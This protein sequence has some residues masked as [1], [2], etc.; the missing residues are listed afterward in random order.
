MALYGAPEGISTAISDVQALN[1]LAMAPMQRAQMQAQT[2]QAQAQTANIIEQAR[3][4]RAQAGIAELQLAEDKSFARA[5]QDSA[6]GGPAETNRP[7]AGAPTGTTAISDLIGSRMMLAWQAG[8]PNKA[9]ELATKYS[10]LKGHE[11]TTA[12][13]TARAQAANLQITKAKAQWFATRAM[14]IKDP[15]SW[16][17]LNADYARTW[18]EPSPYAGVPYF[19]G[20]GEKVATEAMT[21][22]ERM[23]AAYKEHTKKS[24]D[25]QRRFTRENQTKM[26]E[27]Q[28]QRLEIERQRATA[29]KKGT[30]GKPPPAP[31]TSQAVDLI[32]RDYLDIEDQDARIKGREIA[33]Q[34]Y[35]IVQ[36]NPNLT[37][38]QAVTRVY[39]QA[40]E[41]GIFKDYL[42][43]PTKGSKVNAEQKA[44][45]EAWGVKYDPGYDY[46]IIG[47]KLKYRKK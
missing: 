10:T 37:P 12:A 5:L 8:A 1:Q 41:K 13:A 46:A 26:R 38:T 19:D 20:M 34:A 31:Y 18:N 35:A 36:E 39:L 15:G 6:L 11:A 14:D 21:V 3:V 16:A 28:R 4:H 30:V 42:K 23:D 44:L 17:A 32:K 7:S 9:I 33:E 40:A 24:T 45:A 22:K 27:I 29:G 2:A 25:E 43:I 47:G